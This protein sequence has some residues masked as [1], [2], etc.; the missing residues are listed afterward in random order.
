[1]ANAYT[2]DRIIDSN[3]RALIKITG[4]LD[5]DM[6]GLVVVDASTLA[7]A[8]NANN[9][10]M[11]ANTHPKA[12]YRTNVIRLWGDVKVDGYLTLQYDGDSNIIQTLGSGSFNMDLDGALAGTVTNDVANTTGDVTLTGVGIGAN[13]AYTIYIDMRKDPRDFNQGQI[14][15]PSSFNYGASGIV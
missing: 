6:S 5:S 1:M 8:M 3:K 2:E 10:L 14:D 11:V 9:L 12:Q 7:Q 13:N 4:T 15:E